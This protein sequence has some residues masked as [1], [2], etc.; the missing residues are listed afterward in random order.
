MRVLLCFAWVLLGLV[1]VAFH[2]GPGQSALVLDQTGSSLRKAKAHAAEGNW[3]SAV[4]AYEAALG[5]IPPERKAETRAIR[6]ERAKAFLEGSQLPNAYNDLIGLV[7]DMREDPDRDPAV[8]ADAQSTLASARYYLTWL[9]RLEGLPQD[10]W[11]E[12]IEAARQTYR[13][14]TEQALA[15]QDQEVAQLHQQNME[16]SIRLARMDLEE[17]QG[18]SLPKQCK[19]CS[20][21]NCKNPGRKKKKEGKK[22]QEDV[23]GAS[24]GLPP[25]SGGS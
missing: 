25:D 22:K 12:E 5:T 20:S 1:M 17:L 13:L 10:V 9:M 2:F 21:G 11:E 8:F 4:S 14:L 18:L 24:S 19:G 16:S 15:S 7:E 6:V 23:R 3:L